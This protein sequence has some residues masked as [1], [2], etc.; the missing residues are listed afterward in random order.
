MTSPSQGAPPS[1]PQPCLSPGDLVDLASALRI[2]ASS[3]EMAAMHFAPDDAEP[4][5]LAARERASV[6]LRRQSARFRKLAGRLRKIN[7]N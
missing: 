2:A 7:S 4:I 5:S 6:A 1:R 3:L